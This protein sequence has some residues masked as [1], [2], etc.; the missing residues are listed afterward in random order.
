MKKASRASLV[1]SWILFT[2]QGLIK[3]RDSRSHKMKRFVSIVAMF[4]EDAVI[5]PI[6]LF[7]V[8]RNLPIPLSLNF[9]DLFEL[10]TLLL[11]IVIGGT[12]V[13]VKISTLF[14][15]KL[16]LEEIYQGD[17]TALKRFL[18]EENGPL[19]SDVKA[20]C[21]LHLL[22]T[23]RYICSLLLMWHKFTLHLYISRFNH[24]VFI[25][26]IVGSAESTA[27]Y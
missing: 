8:I 1:I 18:R 6:N 5:I 19:P 22:A 15:E 23:T 24:I 11:R 14:Y 20:R 13:F 27:Q 12:V 26:F 21:T 3:E 17:Y 25:H 9:R 16:W 2:V 4:L 10:T 7:A